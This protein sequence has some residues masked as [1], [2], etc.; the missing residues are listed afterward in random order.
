MSGA[1][2][3]A[4]EDAEAREKRIACRRQAAC[5]F[6][7]SNDLR[8]L[9]IDLAMRDVVANDVEKQGFALANVITGGALRHS[10]PGESDFEDLVREPIWSSLWG[11]DLGLIEQAAR[12]VQ[13]PKYHCT[14]LR[15]FFINRTV[16]EVFQGDWRQKRSPYWYAFAAIAVLASFVFLGWAGVLV[17]GFVIWRELSR[18]HSQDRVKQLLTE[19]N[20]IYAEVVRGGFDEPTII[21]R[22]EAI[23]QP[24]FA[25]PSVLYALLR[26]PRRNVET[27]ISAAYHELDDA[28]KEDINRQWRRFVDRMLRYDESPADQPLQTA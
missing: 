20:A 22:L 28:K 15:D 25:V 7:Q 3:R 19:G 9:Y 8:W 4:A 11:N 27:E 17:L 16:K 12:Y 26:Q 23:E 14:A 24:G 6:E 1:K 10:M 2:G 13:S 21:R 5:I 18:L